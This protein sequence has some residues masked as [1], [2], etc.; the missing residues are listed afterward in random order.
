MSTPL[1]YVIARQIREDSLEGSIISDPASSDRIALLAK[2]A[3]S[4]RLFAPDSS[5][6]KI[7]CISCKVT[8]MI[9]SFQYSFRSHRNDSEPSDLQS[10][11]GLA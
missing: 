6:A 1:R 3:I 5:S 4:S 11:G 8:C 9:T 2:A 7:L 10:R